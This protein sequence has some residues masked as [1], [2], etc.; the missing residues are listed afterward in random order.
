MKYL[1]I[2]ISLTIL[3][4]NQ[5][6]YNPSN[7]SLQN[8]SN[9]VS[10]ENF[11][12]I[13]KIIQDSIKSKNNIKDC[14]LDY[15]FE[16]SKSLVE[17]KTKEYFKNGKFINKIPSHELIVKKPI[18]YKLKLTDDSVLFGVDFFFTN[19]NILYKI[20]LGSLVEAYSENYFASIAPFTLKKIFQIFQ[21]K[22]DTKWYFTKGKLVDSEKE[23]LSYENIVGNRY[24]CLDF[25][26]RNITITYKNLTLEEKMK[27]DNLNKTKNDI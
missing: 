9:L 7:T 2:I 18:M 23:T 20:E 22:Y 15:K 16:D 24:I 14:F 1:I 17:R 11:N 4:C 12:E 8:D 27:E 13:Q 25:D 5:K 10:I 6:R 21:K 26:G 19:R 3:S